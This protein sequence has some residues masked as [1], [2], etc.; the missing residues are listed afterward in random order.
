MLTKNDV[1]TIGDLFDEK[2]DKKFDGKFESA[3][4]KHTTSI[5]EDIE[6]IRKDQKLIIKFFDREYLNLRKR[7]E[8][9]ESY[10]KLSAIN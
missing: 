4:K 10:L 9:I 3:F 1:K 5:K 6:Q 7:V 2:F 8:R